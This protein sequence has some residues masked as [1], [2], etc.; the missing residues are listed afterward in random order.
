MI[1]VPDQ[2]KKVIQQIKQIKRKD[3]QFQL[4]SEMNPFMVNQ[5]CVKLKLW[6]S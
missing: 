4:L 3:Q 2:I 1:F 5:Y 6:I